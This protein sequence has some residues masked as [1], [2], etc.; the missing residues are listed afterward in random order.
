MAAMAAEDQLQRQWTVAPPVQVRNII[1]IEVGFTNLQNNQCNQTQDNRVSVS[2]NLQRDQSDEGLPGRDKS[3]QTKEI[4]FISS[5]NAIMG[6]W[7]NPEGVSISEVRRNKVLISFKD[8]WRGLQTLKGGPWSI[9]GHLLNLQLWSQ[10][11]SISEVSHQYMEFWVQIH[12]LPLENM[13]SETSRIIGDMMGI[14]IDVEDPMRNHVL[15]RTFLR[16][17]VAVDILKPL[18]TGFYMAR[19]NLPSIWVHFKYECLQ[20]CYCMN[21][22]VIRHS[23]KE[24]N[25]EMII[26]QG[27]EKNENKRNKWEKLQ[28]KFKICKKEL[29]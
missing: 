6:I 9:K 1:R 22:G 15:I 19:E 23:K 5:K 2:T 26:K 16:V 7:E 17:R 27:W 25:K 3:Y 13:N 29:E 4:P 14:V 18:A 20:D 21:Y 24:C 8:V 10:H 12:R 11:E 28:E